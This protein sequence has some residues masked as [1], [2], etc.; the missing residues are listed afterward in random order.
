MENL[1]KNKSRKLDHY[2]NERHDEASIPFIDE[3]NISDQSQMAEIVLIENENKNELDFKHEIK[4]IFKDIDNLKYTDE[5]IIENIDRLIYMNSSL[6]KKLQITKSGYDNISLLHAAAR[7][8][9]G[10]VCAYLID[11]INIDKNVRSKSKLTPMHIIVKSNSLQNETASTRVLISTRM[12]V[13]SVAKSRE[14][15]KKA[16]KVNKIDVIIIK[17]K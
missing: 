16:V 14:F 11:I 2:Q 7:V 10:K 5:E 3:K 15:Q 13:K 6:K 1:L 17:N 4:E 8:C 12:S 9:R